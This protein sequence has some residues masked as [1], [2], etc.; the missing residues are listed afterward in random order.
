MLV[1]AL[2][3]GGCSRRGDDAAANLDALNV[4]AEA[5]RKRIEEQRRLMR[6]LR[7]DCLEC[8]RAIEPVKGAGF[9]M[10]TGCAV[11]QACHARTRRRALERD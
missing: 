11:C 4:E 2:C 3:I 8:G 9:V 1:A 10:A 7:G 5:E 6:Q